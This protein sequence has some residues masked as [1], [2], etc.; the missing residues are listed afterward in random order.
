M[1][2]LLLILS[3]SSR[4][5]DPKQMAV[6]TSAPNSTITAVEVR[7]Q[8]RGRLSRRAVSAIH[9]HQLP[10]YRLGALIGLPASTLGAW[11]H[12]IVKPRLDDVRVSRL[13]KLLGLE[14]SAMW[15]EETL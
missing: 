4:A 5:E 10:Q 6:P 8:Q 7:R 15:D 13:A 14:S 3:L 9:H 1:G 11:V 12:G 2:R